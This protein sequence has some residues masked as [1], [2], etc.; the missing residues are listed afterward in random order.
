MGS[1]WLVVADKDDDPIV[2]VTNQEN[3]P[4]FASYETSPL[5]PIADSFS[6]FLDA[7]AVTLEI[8]HEKF[9]GEIMDEETFDI[10]DDFIEMLKSSL[11]SI[12]KKEEYADNF[13][14]YLYG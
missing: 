3:S 1:N 14:D 12:L 6:A 8:I 13:I 11:S 4:V 5:F 2:V 7:L 10:Y 9:K